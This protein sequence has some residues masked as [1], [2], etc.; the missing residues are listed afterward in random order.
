MILVYKKKIK[1]KN[2]DKSNDEEEEENEEEDEKNQNI[3][4]EGYLLKIRKDGELKQ[5][6][7]K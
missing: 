6:Y 5:L 1:K 3:K 4:F 7:F 2:N